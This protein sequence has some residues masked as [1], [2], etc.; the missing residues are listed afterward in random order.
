MLVPRIPPGAWLIT[1][2]PLTPSQRKRQESQVQRKSWERTCDLKSL[3]EVKEV[4]IP[5]GKE[6]YKFILVQRTFEMHACILFVTGVFHELF[7]DLSC[8]DF[9]MLLHPTEAIFVEFCFLKSRH[10][11]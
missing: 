10:M 6:N 9:K 5:H 4:Q 3:R 1:W 2:V 7:E 8:M 11:A